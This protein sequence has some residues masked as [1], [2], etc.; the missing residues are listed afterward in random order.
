MSQSA[1]PRFLYGVKLLYPVRNLRFSGQFI[2]NGAAIKI[3]AVVFMGF[4]A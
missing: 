4:P 1:S 3:I 2:I